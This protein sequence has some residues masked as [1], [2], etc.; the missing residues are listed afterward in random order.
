MPQHGKKYLE[1]AKLV[2]REQTYSPAE[3]AALAKQTT[4]VNF[5]ATIEAHL[6]LGVDPRHADQMVRGTVV[7]P[8]GT[9]PGGELHGIRRIVLG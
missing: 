8:H 7:L 9:G 1:A 6:R 2:D 4:A 3:A 5:D